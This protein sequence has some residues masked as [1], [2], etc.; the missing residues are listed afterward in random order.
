MSTEKVREDRCRRALRRRGMLLKKTPARSWLRQHYG[1]GYMIVDERN[2]VVA[3]YD[4]RAYRLAL[5]D[6]EELLLGAEQPIGA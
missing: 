4:G 5:A 3:G 2:R 6:V 1:A